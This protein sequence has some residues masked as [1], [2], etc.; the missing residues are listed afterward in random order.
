[1]SGT[2]GAGTYAEQLAAWNEEFWRALKERDNAVARYTEYCHKFYRL[3][4]QPEPPEE[5]DELTRLRGT[6]SDYSDVVTALQMR[7]A[8][9]QESLRQANTELAARG[10]SIDDV[11]A[12][13]PTAGPP[14]P[15]G[16]ILEW[17]DNLGPMTR[18]VPRHV[19]LA[20]LKAAGA[21]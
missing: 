18:R 11:V 5:E 8:V 21:K 15:D 12:A 10:P 6:V 13:L 19:I 1:M 9:L 17:R 7:I 14:C 4:P 20:A 2:N 16:F 3:P